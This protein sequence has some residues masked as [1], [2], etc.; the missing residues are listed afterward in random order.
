MSTRDKLA[1]D[2][3]RIRDAIATLYSVTSDDADELWAAL[4]AARAMADLL[5]G[6]REC[7]AGEDVR[8]IGLCAAVQ[9]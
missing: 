9:R 5:S 7:V 6:E 8:V 4:I 1:T 3:K 2:A